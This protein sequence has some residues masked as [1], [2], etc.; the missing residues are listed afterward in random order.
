MEAGVRVGTDETHS[1]F[2]Q[3][4][5]GKNLP[6]VAQLSHPIATK[7]R[8]GHTDPDRENGVTQVLDCPTSL[9]NPSRSQEK[10]HGSQTS[11]PRTRWVNGLSWLTHLAEADLPC[12][13]FFPSSLCCISLIC[14]D[15]TKT[16][17]MRPPR[18]TELKRGKFEEMNRPSLAELC[19]AFQRGDAVVG[20]SIFTSPPLAAHFDF[21][22]WHFLA[23][24]NSNAWRSATRTH[25]AFVSHSFRTQSP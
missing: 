5:V 20:R 25:F 21:M 1:I 15:K 12:P 6:N 4:R 10:R 22:A 16:F 11:V 24:G 7:P 23:L 18:T 14:Q 9:P 2:V 17:G 13:S 8:E 3:D 19:L